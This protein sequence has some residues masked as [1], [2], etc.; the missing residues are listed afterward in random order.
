MSQDCP[1]PDE[2][3]AFAAGEL[4][5]TAKANVEAHVSHCDACLQTVGYLTSKSESDI[6][7]LAHPALAQADQVI[8]AYRLVRRLGEGG[9]GEV[10]EAQQSEPVRRRVALKLLKAGMDTRQI[11]TRFQAERQLLALMQHPC[12]AQIYDAGITD[13][14]R[15]YFVMEYVEGLRITTYCDHARLGVRE[16]LELFKEVCAAVQHAHQ[17][18]VI[19]RDLKPSN[20]LVTLRDGK[21]LPKVID[22]GLAKATTSEAKDN[23]LTEVGTL[24][25]TPA[26]AS[27]EQMSMG[28]IDIDTRSDVY[29]LGALLYELLVGVLPIE[30]DGKH[31]VIELRQ[32]IRDLDPPR[33][34]V[35]ISRLGERLSEIAKARGVEPP[36][37]RSQ[38][39]GDLD[40]IVMKALEKQRERRYASPHELSLDIDRYLNHEPLLARP[41]TTGYLIRKFVRR[42]RVGASFVAVIFVVLVA[43]VAVTLIQSQRVA[44]ERD[45]ATAQAERAEAINAFLQETLG[46]ADPWQTGRDVSVR[47]TLEQAAAKIDSTFQSQPLLAAEVRRTIGSIYAS[48][49][50]YEDAEPLLLSALETRRSLLG[51]EHEDVAD[52]LSSLAALYLPETRYDEAE[53]YA[54]DALDMRKKLLG[55]SH[56]AVG[57]SF[58]QLA[59]VLF[60]KG[61]YPEAANA[62]E[63]GVAI[64]EQ[65]IDSD[66]G[67]VSGALQMLAT[68]VGNGLGDYP[69]AE[70][71]YTRA[72]EIEVR[73]SGE[74]HLR[75]AHA[76]ANLATHYLVQ[77]DYERAERLLKEAIPKVRQHLGD[78]H[79][80]V[81]SFVENLG[82]VMLRLNRFDEAL[83]FANEALTIRKNRLGEEN[84]N[85][86]RT[87]INIAIV[88][89]FAGR[90]DD[91]AASYATALPRMKQAY[92]EKHPDVA[93]VL[94]MYG[95]L[96]RAQKL[97]AQAEALFREALAIQLATQPEDHPLTADTR[98]EL[99]R[100]LFTQKQYDEAE[101]LLVQAYTAHEKT[102]GVDARQTRDDAFVLAA[103]YEA[104]G[105]EEKAARYRSAAAA[106]QSIEP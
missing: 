22:F 21:P 59:E 15:P 65:L 68:I 89:Y 41:P 27:P 72:Y 39:R 42:H 18:G 102:F 83:Q 19:H 20:V 76:G 48:L 46:A 62:A 93:A 56:R 47:E 13:A 33:P 28:A 77:G 16:R 64:H 40:W 3:A 81:A 26:Y 66:P 73:A 88:Q 85:V 14:G 70:E 30:A 4:P 95:R 7:P 97:D 32:A 98:F 84:A 99:G 8:G 101:A 57:D 24:L 45:R 75:A 103:L 90:L 44:E 38:L 69:R 100:L 31:S 37:L 78:D 50:R 94:T 29:S 82:G 60:S 54:R 49:G 53:K 2:L 79:P 12:I 91:S 96:R 80:I 34:S 35:R 52:S 87:M 6:E 9:M 51:A 55:D 67:K 71:L 92:G 61:S 63:A 104:T 23:S 11:V 43:F 105:Q 10:W 17:K 25:G 86:I 58:I 106:T 1:S 74:N 36:V 5:A